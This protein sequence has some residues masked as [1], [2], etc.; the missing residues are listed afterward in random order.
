M[1][2]LL[3]TALGKKCER[4]PI[5]LMRQAGRYMPEYR[6][7][8]EKFSFLEMC[9]QYENAVEVTMQPI[10]ILDVDAAIL[11]SD[12]L[13]PLIPMGFDLKFYEGRGPVI[14]NPIENAEDVSRV[15]VP[16]VKKGSD[17]VYDA[18]SA[19][20]KKLSPEKDLIGF[21]GAPFTVAS[22]AIE[23]GSSKNYLKIKTF[24]YTQPKAYDE[25]M[26]KI[27]EMTCYY[28]L[29]QFKAGAQIVQIFDSWGGVLSREDYLKYSHPYTVKIID[30]IKKETGGKPVIHFVKGANAYFDSVADSQ[31]DVLG[32][33][34]TLPL[35]VAKD[36]CNNSRVLQ[37]NLDP[38][39][40]FSNK[41]ILADKLELIREQAK[42]LKG[43]IFNLGH[44]IMPKTP[45]ENVKFVVD[46]VKSWRNN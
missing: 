16:D 4:T 14:H 6:A 26:N 19:I 36:L 9:M 1:G 8:R 33:D 40:L 29:E 20:R 38:A 28:L 12:I 44:G 30:F 27:A 2:L 5:W 41:E 7:V 45:V 13:T 43:H 11:F 32:T 25:L 3:D 18:L 35:N 34:W 42:G 15:V 10:D 23:G 46:T 37:G 21:S 39:S 22:Y 17:Y 24:M 31:A